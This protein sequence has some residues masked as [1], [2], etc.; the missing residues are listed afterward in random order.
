MT[1][2]LVR[3]ADGSTAIRLDPPIWVCFYCGEQCNGRTEAENHFGLDIWESCPAACVDPLRTD[4]KERQAAWMDLL[5]ELEGERAESHE[6]GAE[7]DSLAGEL[8]AFR[9]LFR[10]LGA[11][12][13]SDAR[14]NLDFLEGRALAAEAAVAE[15]KRRAPALWQTIQ[16]HICRP[17]TA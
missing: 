10:K 11:D 2:E 6:R 1:L 3:Q 7:I 13:A 16:D 9:E 15:L 8:A 12:T 5:R 17:V 14:H 4:E